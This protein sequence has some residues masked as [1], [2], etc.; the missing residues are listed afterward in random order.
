[1]SPDDQAFNLHA[2]EVAHDYPGPYTHVEVMAPDADDIMARVPVE[3]VRKIIT[4]HG[5]EVPAQPGHRHA[6][7]I[8]LK[9]EETQP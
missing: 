2:G 6:A 7:C 1:M 5:G 8:E 9:D 3:D 4:E